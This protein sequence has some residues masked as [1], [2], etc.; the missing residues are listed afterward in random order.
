MNIIKRELRANLKAFIIW[1]AL[2]MLII[3]AASSEF[4][5]FRN[6]PELLEL[7]DEPGMAML[8]EGIGGSIANVTKPE[9]FLSIFSIY[10]YVPLSIYAALLG[11]SIIS[12]EERDRTAEYLYT[13]P[14]KRNEVILRK[15]ITAVFYVLAFI[16]ILIT[17]VIL[18]FSRFNP[19][20]NFYSFMSYLTIALTFTSLMFLSIGMMFASILK[21][22]KKSGSITL[23]IL[24]G[25]YMLNI[26]VRLVDELEFLKYIIPF[27]Y[28]DVTEM[29]NGNIEFIFVLLSLII[30]GSCITAVFYF[31]KRRDL[32]I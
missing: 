26:L 25:S 22:Y 11:S 32:Y 27:Q 17:G 1:V 30:I 2:L 18:M 3:F 8:F 14:I 9:G 5:V 15:M 12:K 16:G 29:L 23:G 19:D 6:N 24:L 28:F 7:M 4:N 13:L 31:Y 20:E 21:Q 10:L